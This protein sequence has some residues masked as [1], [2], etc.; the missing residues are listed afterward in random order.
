MTKDNL[1]NTCC[2]D[3]CK[4]ENRQKLKDYLMEKQEN[5]SISD[6]NAELGCHRRTLARVLS[7]MVED[8][9]IESLTNSWDYRVVLPDTSW[10]I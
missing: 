6:L 4:L 3:L 8:G 9:Q 10:K 7:Q 2:S 1:D 5:F